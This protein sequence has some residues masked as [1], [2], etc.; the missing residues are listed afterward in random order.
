MQ[1]KIRQI[2][3]NLESENNLRSLK[4]IR[5]S[6]KY[7]TSPM[8]KQTHQKE[9]DFLLAHPAYPGSYIKDAM[10]N[11]SSNDY[12]GIQ[13]DK[14]LTQAFLEQ[15]LP[16][17][18]ES[19]SPIFSS[20]SSRSLSGNHKAFQT[21]ET[22]LQNLFNK[23]CTTPP[24]A[25]LL[26][27]SGY[28][29]N[30]GI[31][32]A[33]ASIEGVLF[34]CDSYVHASIFDGLRLSRAKFFRY[35]H[36][37]YDELTSLILQH[38]KRFPHIIIIT[39]SL[40]SMDGDFCDIERLVEIKKS[41]NTYLY[42]DC[43]HSFGIYGDDMLGL[44]SRFIDDV[45]FII[46]AF[47]KAISSV[48]GAII[49][50]PSYR[51][52]FINKSRSFIYSTAIPPLNISWSEYIITHLSSLKAKKSHLINISTHLQ[53]ELK[54]HD[55]PF[56][57]DAHIISILAYENKKATELSHFLANCKIFTPAIK[58]PTIPKNL[59]RIRLSLNASLSFE[60]I[61]YLLSC[62]KLAKDILKIKRI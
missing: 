42:I 21:L 38:Q 11:L 32:D 9:L 5:C 3:A 40:F 35:S 6:S 25:A 23:T 45:D 33:L 10:L 1:E 28:H 24:K 47:G 22:T 56:L 62:L 34:L 57:G 12:L 58:A 31:I 29:A 53:E 41:L 44:D 18:L 60:D 4:E 49:C 50:A 8:S 52:L 46:L 59:A 27:N 2:L 16:S 48:G 15:N 13:D 19:N 37:D 26:F 51:D 36:Q 7:I 17:L 14:K 43:A 61:D 54:R 55:I 30:I 39:E 20:S